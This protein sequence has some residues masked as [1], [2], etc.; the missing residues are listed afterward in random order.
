MGKSQRDK[1]NR[2]E[3]GIVNII[4]SFGFE[5]KRVPLSG[6][7][8]GFKGDI[9]ATFPLRSGDDVIIESKVRANGFKSLYK[10]LVGNDMLIVRAD[11]E[12]HLVIMPL[13]DYLRDIR[14]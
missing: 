14:G 8:K 12:K 13:E 4:S 2:E 7:M 10:W 9:R 5:C 3:C 6:S 11:R 1:G